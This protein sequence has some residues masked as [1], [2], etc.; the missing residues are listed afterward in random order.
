[1]RLYGQAP[2]IDGFGSESRLAPPTGSDEVWVRRVGEDT[3]L[4]WFDANDASPDGGRITGFTVLT[5]YAGAV[6]AAHL[7]S[8]DIL[9]R[10]SRTGRDDTGSSFR[11]V[12][13]D[14]GA[15]HIDGGDGHD[16]LY[17]DDGDDR[18]YG[19]DGNDTL[20]GHD[21]DDRLY[22]GDGNDYLSGRDGDDRLY[23]G[24]GNDYL[25]WP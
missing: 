11:S 10:T 18:L 1:M 25:Q 17:G 21:G 19:G 5:G 20:Y 3:L 7:G 24:D 16:T 8:E 9:I 12:Y 15:D 4:T 13:G 23:G 6:T 2:S 22:G 14:D